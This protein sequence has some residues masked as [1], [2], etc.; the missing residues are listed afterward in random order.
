MLP[1]V[2]K[3]PELV[4][5]N[6]SAAA[7]PP[8]I[9]LTTK[10]K[11]SW[12]D[13][14]SVVNASK[15]IPF[16]LLSAAVS[17]VKAISIPIPFWGDWSV[18]WTNSNISNVLF[19]ADEL[20]V[21]VMPVSCSWVITTSWSLPRLIVP[22]SA[23]YKS[24]HSNVVL[25]N[26][27]P[28]FADGKRL[29]VEVSVLPNVTVPVTSKFPDI[30]TSS[31]PSVVSI[32]NKPVFPGASNVTDAELLSV[33]VIIPLST[34]SF[35]IGFV[36]VLFVSTSV[37][38]LPTNVSVVSGNVILLSAVEFIINVVSALTLDPSKSKATVLLVLVL[39]LTTPSPLACKFKSIFV[40]SPVALTIGPDPVAAFVTVISFTAVDIW[41]NF[42]NS[43]PAASAIN[44]VSANF[45]AVNVLFDNVWAK[46]CITI[47]PSFPPKSGKE[48]DAS[49]VWLLVP[50]T[51]S[52]LKNPIVSPTFKFP[53][54]AVPPVTNNEPV[55][56]FVEAWP[57]DKL[58]TPDEL[59]EIASVSPVEPI[60]PPFAT[61][62]LPSKFAFNV[63]CVPENVL[64]L[65][66]ASGIN[67]NLE[68]VLSKPKN[69]NL[70]VPPTSYLNLI[71]LSKLSAS[72]SLPIS[73]TGSI[74]LILVEFTVVVVP[75]TVKFPWICTI[76]SPLGFIL[77][78]PS[79]P[80]SI[81]IV[82]VVE[83]PVCKIKSWSPDEDRVALAAPVPITILP[84]PL[85]TK[86]KS[87]LLSSPDAL[88]V[89]AKVVAAF[90]IVISLTA[91]F[92]W[93]KIKISAPLASAINPLYANFGAVKVLFVK[94]SVVAL[95]TK[96]SFTSG[97]VRSLVD[98]GLRDSITGV[99][100]VLFVKV[101]VVALPTNVSLLSIG[102][103]NVKLDVIV[104]GADNVIV[105]VPLLEFS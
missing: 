54:I 79:V 70:L 73:I 76:P 93:S 13:V 69:P 15:I 16:S 27:A 53:V 92:N 30:F 51:K 21:I 74:I 43:N 34:I 40:S 50:T 29:P 68:S 64:V 87:I 71:P 6:L 81:V 5:L 75:V 103:V 80:S 95:P 77:I 36:N 85:G 78:F 60:V 38:A 94:V 83:F 66:V 3:S 97:I 59:I 99:V 12:P 101:S 41:E 24:D 23:K 82:P 10:S 20:E 88:T 1:T 39:N 45:G 44:P 65:S 46:L 72:P 105:F 9:N 58:T 100:N 22:P 104:P 42:I 26:E 18:W 47:S 52:W 8:S 48:A 61:I 49:E 11:S 2:V 55:V 62:T 86:F 63:P 84:V 102:N 28:S 90:L 98:E 67:K 4:T 35:T 37:V 96:V 56:P 31:D 19:V 33:N 14:T 57:A 17:T 25:P 7:D 91:L 89:G 32:T